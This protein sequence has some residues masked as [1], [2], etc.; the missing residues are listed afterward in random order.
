MGCCLKEA[1]DLKKEGRRATDCK[2]FKKKDICAVRW[3]EN[4]AVTLASSFVG[5]EPIDHVRRWNAAEKVY[6][7]V[8]RPACVQVYNEFMGGV[9][10]LDSLISYYRIRGKTK[11]WLLRVIY[12]FVDFA[13]AN[14]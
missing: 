8:C 2:V 5:V 4:F 14:S 11:K 6:L 1:K 13:L 10:K 12:H 9:D 7:M 3:F